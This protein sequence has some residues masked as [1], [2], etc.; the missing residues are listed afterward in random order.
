MKQFLLYLS[1]IA[2]LASCSGK[3]QV[4]RAIHSGNY[5]QAI[6]EAMQKLRGNKDS[7]RNQDFILMLRD[8]FYKAVERDLA[9]VKFLKKENNP[10]QYR[11]LYEIF[12]DLDARQNSIKPL[13]PLVVDGKKIDFK[14][15][16]YSNSIIKYKNLSSDHLYDQGLRLLE[17]DDKAK[18]REA[19]SIYSYIESIN[20]NYENTRELLEEAHQ[21]GT[22]HII[23]SVVNQT[24]QIIPMRLENE[25]LAFNTYGLNQFWTQYH[26]E[27]EAIR[28]TKY[29]LAMQLQLKRILIAPEQMNRREILRE[30]NIKDGW[31]YKKDANGNVMKDS[32]GNDIKIDKI[33]KVQAR[34]AEVEQRK[35]SQ[36]LAEAVYMDL[37]ANRVI[38]RFPIDSGF[39][40]VNVFGTFRGDKRALTPDDIRLLNNRQMIF[41]S[42][43]QMV[44]NTGEDL[45]AKLKSVISRYRVSR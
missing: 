6:Q 17:T 44:F 30:Q 40:F 22:D 25:L 12:I 21:R 38:D 43:E 41:P 29:D 31:D 7:K 16:D 37:N 27:K 32:L 23:V 35:T 9:D 34:F 5:D 4:A 18:I 3:K 1:I 15:N 28:D 11:E 33:K 36:I 24:N 39:D 2:M 42:N 13:L 19:H 20:P 8:G 26:S 45:K 10:D 14:F